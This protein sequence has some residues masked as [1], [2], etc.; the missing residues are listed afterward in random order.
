MEIK[1][2]PT[3]SEP[4]KAVDFVKQWLVSREVVPMEHDE[5]RE[6]FAQILAQCCNDYYRYRNDV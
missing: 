1:L 6:H 2:N 3:K 5:E 4:E